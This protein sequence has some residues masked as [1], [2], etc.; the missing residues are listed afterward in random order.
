M[1]TYRKFDWNRARKDFATL[2]TDFFTYVTGEWTTT[3]V[4]TGTSALAD[5]A[6][7]VLVVT[8]SGADNDAR[9]AQWAGNGGATKETFKFDPNKKLQFVGRFKLSDATDCDFFAGL[10]ITDTDPV[11]GVT[12]GIYFRKLDGTNKLSFV[13]EKNSA[14]TVLEVATLANDT[15]FDLEF[16]WAADGQKIDAFVNG[17]RVGGAVTTNA[18]DDEELA[19]SF[20]VQAGS[21]NARALSV[22][23]IGAQ[24]Q[25]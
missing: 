9:W 23:Y 25:R 1:S 18:P 17:T 11:G 2:F 10:Y 6:G 20:G 16:Y 7:G 15:Y 14:E 24:Q 21:G 4:G 8:T 5:A 22:D 3:V 19:L 12:D 13:V